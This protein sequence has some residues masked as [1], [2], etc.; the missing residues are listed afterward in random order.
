MEKRNL[1]HLE[2]FRVIAIYWVMFNHTGTDG[3]FLFSI[4]EGSFLYP[5]V[6]FY[7]HWLQIRGAAVF[8]GFRGAAAGEK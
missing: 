6:S 4:S 7:V 3:F 5:R 2:L 8:Y 1:T